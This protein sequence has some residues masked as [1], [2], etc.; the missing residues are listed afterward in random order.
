MQPNSDLEGRLCALLATQAY[1]PLRQHELAEALQLH[2]DEKQ[3]LR[4]LLRDLERQGRLICLRKN[5]WALPAPNRLSRSVLKALPSGGAI[6]FP[7]EPPGEDFFIDRDSLAGAIDADRVLIEPLNRRYRRDGDS[8]RT[9]GRVVRVLERERRPIAGTMIKGRGYWYLIPDNNRVAAHVRVT[10]FSSAIG[11]PKANHKMVVQLDDWKGPSSTLTGTAVEDLG[12]MDA[13]GVTLLS[14]MRNH[15]LDTRFESEVDHEARQQSA[16]LTASDIQG[17]EDLRGWITFTIDPEDARDFD[18]AISLRRLP[19]GQWE[20]GVHIADVAH[21]VSP[22]SEIDREARR[23]GNSVYLVGGFVPMLP[24]YLTSD[25]C[26]LRP[27]VDRLTHTVLLTLDAKGRVLSARTFRSVIHSVARLD[28]DQ[29]QRFMD[30]GVEPSISEIVRQVLLD[31]IPL[32]RVIRQRRM[33]AGSIDLS[34]PEVKCELNAEGRAVAFHRRGAPEAYH[35]IEEFML[36]ANVAVAEA[37]STRRVPALY[38]IHEEPSDEQWAG[39]AREL[40]LLGLLRKPTNPADINSVCR[41]VAKTPMEYPVN[42]A[43]LRSMK[44]ALYSDARV[45]HFGL[46]FSTYTHFTSPIRRYPDLVVHRILC[47]LE[48]RKQPPYSHDDMRRIGQHCSATER[49]ADDAETESLQE[50]RIAYYAARCAA[51]EV[52]PHAALITG[53]LGR[54]LLVELEDSLQRG[55][56]PLSALPSDGYE[57]NIQRG[58]VRGRHTRKTFRVG[59]RVEVELLRVDEVR[60]LVDF[61]MLSPGSTAPLPASRSKAARKAHARKARRRQRMR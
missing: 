33:Q 51:G 54:G 55:L 28:Y 52:G 56:I 22:E 8:G 21:F 23:R 40:E 24:A 3:T 13:T 14:L 42:L 47:A 36:L 30:Q 4:H 57:V 25:V 31:M 53:V 58:F 48:D 46:G 7:L 15:G 43:I 29:V 1:R 38:R 9:P 10:G 59:T 49:T 45:G 18:D 27:N 11:E 19:D 61:R 37:I 41:E 12:P 35:L 5:R 26:S 2:R 39:M 44:R 20:A 6:A 50:Q 16:V 17:R 32:A 34:M 60:R